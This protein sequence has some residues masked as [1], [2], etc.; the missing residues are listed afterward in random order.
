MLAPGCLS[1]LRSAGTS[2][3]APAGPAVGT[4]RSAATATASIIRCIA[5]GYIAVQVI[6]W[7]SFYAADPWR[8]AGPAVAAA[9]SVALVAYLLRR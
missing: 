5:I 1:R 2:G 6:I 7:H 8:L 3:G 4:L 9:W